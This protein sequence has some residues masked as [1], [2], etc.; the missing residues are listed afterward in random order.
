ML[1]EENLVKLLKY[2]ILSCHMYY[3][4]VE[5]KLTLIR[6]MLIF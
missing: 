2:E 6:Q 1:I 3:F 5:V 4:V